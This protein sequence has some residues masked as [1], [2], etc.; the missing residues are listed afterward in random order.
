VL[1]DVAVC[2]PHEAETVGLI[3]GVVKSA[4][5]SFRVT[6]E[7][8]DDI[9]LALS[10]AC[11][12]V[13]EHA[14]H[15]DEY[16]VGVQVDEQHCALSVKN[17]AHG[18]DAAALRGVMP[19][20]SSPRGRGVAIM[21]TLMDQVDFDSGEENGTIVHLVKTLTIEPDGLLDRLRR[22]PR[23]PRRRSAPSTPLRHA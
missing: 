16:E 11:N 1:L 12:N 2:L 13:I 9:C 20:P 8:I 14:I 5:R 17:T 21:R 23:A 22:R 3:R 15:G 4:L 18:F 19:D 7:C 10:E 6:D